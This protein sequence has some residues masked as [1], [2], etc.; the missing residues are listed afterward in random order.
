MYIEANVLKMGVS[1][2]HSMLLAH[3]AQLE[4]NHSSANL[5]HIGNNQRKDIF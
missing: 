3:E 1:E 4:S 2:V 5:A